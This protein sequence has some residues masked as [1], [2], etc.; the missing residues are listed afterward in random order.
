MREPSVRRSWMDVLGSP[1]STPS[2]GCPPAVEEGI[3]TDVAATPLLPEGAASS[4]ASQAKGAVKKVR[5]SP[6]QAPTK[7]K[8]EARMWQHEHTERLAYCKD[9]AML[10]KAHQASI[11]WPNHKITEPITSVH[12]LNI[13]TTT[14][15]RLTMNRGVK[16]ADWCNWREPEVRLIAVRSGTRGT[17]V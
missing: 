14:P 16:N 4:P 1:S 12:G 5:W 13:I 7:G 10:G 8:T 11:M 9:S 6:T 17:E 3:A 15:P 2:Q